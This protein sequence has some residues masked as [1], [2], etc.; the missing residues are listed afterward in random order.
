M[1]NII[2]TIL[3]NIILLPRN[4][5]T[6]SHSRP[7]CGPTDAAALLRLAALLG[8]E[9]AQLHQKAGPPLHIGASQEAALA[10]GSGRIQRLR[11]LRARPALRVG[12]D[13][14]EGEQQPGHA[15]RA[16]RALEAQLRLRERACKPCNLE[17][18][19]QPIIDVFLFIDRTIMHQFMEISCFI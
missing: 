18:R 8:E 3:V 1:K 12:D 5:Q 4:P 16:E 10:Q 2:K 6:T 13:E 9:V 14:A 19:Q 17:A 11:A 15:L 7:W